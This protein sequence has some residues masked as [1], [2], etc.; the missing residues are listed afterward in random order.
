MK[1]SHELKAALVK[2]GFP[3][4][5]VESAVPY[6]QLKKVIKKV[7]TELG[8]LGLDPETLGQLIVN[9]DQETSSIRRG[10][11]VAFQYD[12]DGKY[13]H[14][15]SVDDRHSAISSFEQTLSLKR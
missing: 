2:E 10:S 9:S 5:W 1:F 7:T 6:S 3:A 11:G 15:S 12:L 4:H 8:S 14:V 13:S